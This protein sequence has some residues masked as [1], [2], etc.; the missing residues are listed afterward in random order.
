MARRFAGVIII[1]SFIVYGIYIFNCESCVTCEPDVSYAIIVS[2]VAATMVGVIQFSLNR[3]NQTK[4]HT[5]NVI[6]ESRFSEFFH[7]LLSSFWSSLGNHGKVCLLDVI[8]SE[9]HA[10]HRNNFKR[11]FD[12]IMTIRSLA[13]Y[14]EFIAASIRSK[15]L[16]ENLSKECIGTM[17]V[18]FFRRAETFI[19][20]RRGEIDSNG[21][22]KEAT[23]PELFK[24]LIWLYE[25]WAP[26]YPTEEL[27]VMPPSDPRQA[28]LDLSNPQQ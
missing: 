27:D 7:E 12:M 18:H 15:D 21:S 13:N 11:E 19:R 5:I 2:V 4:Q 25:R 1:V 28:S 6:F 16:D 10:S 26:F 9:K 17:V 3:E 22:K 24:N 14:Y 8:N 20:Y 23:R